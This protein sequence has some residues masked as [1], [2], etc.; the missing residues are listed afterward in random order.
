M[1]PGDGAAAKAG[2]RGV[3]RRQARWLIA[4]GFL[5]VLLA[6]VGINRPSDTRYFAAKIERGEI[7]DVVEATGTISAVVTV[8]VGSQVS[9]TIAKLFADFNSRVHK[10]DRVALIDAALFQ[11]ALLQAAADL[12]NARANLTAAEANLEKARAGLVQA[13]A[14]F[15]RA[16]GLAQQGVA[17]PQQLDQA[18]A[19]HDSAKAIVGA[20]AASVTQARA[21]VNQKAAAVSVAETNLDYTVIS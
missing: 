4:L 9:G 19:N 21:Q 6:A 10:G 3:V 8:Q 5:V 20:I 7:R 12:E 18:R 11:G 14:D 13:K 15:E 16:D 17:S 2:G 1:E